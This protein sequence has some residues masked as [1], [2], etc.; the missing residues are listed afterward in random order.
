MDRRTFD[1]SP[2][3]TL[4]FRSVQVGS[5]DRAKFAIC[6]LFAFVARLVLPKHLVDLMVVHWGGFVIDSSVGLLFW[7]DSTRLI[8][9]FFCALFNLMNS[10]MFAIG[11]FPY[12]MLIVLP[13]Y[14][15]PDWPVKVF[16]W[17]GERFSANKISSDLAKKFEISDE[18]RNQEKNTWPEKDEPKV[19][20]R[21]NRL[22]DEA[23]NTN[24]C[25]Q[26]G[27]TDQTDCKLTPRQKIIVILL[28]LFITFQVFLPF[29]HN[30]TKGFNTWTD[31]IYGYSWDMMVHNWRIL[32]KKITIKVNPGEHELYLNTEKWSPNNRWTHHADMAKQFANCIAE[33]L[34]HQYNLSDISIHMDVWISLNGR[35]VQRVFDPRVDLLTVDWSPFRKPSF[36]MPLIDEFTNWRTKLRQIE[37]EMMKRED[38]SSVVFMADFPGN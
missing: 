3:R 35:F 1:A 20:R 22:N 26:N 14:S 23:K 36:V 27:R 29:S 38:N 18:V 16:N 13:I 31:G 12:V 7:F 37:D 11:M 34:R 17:V 8:G 25:E 32:D 10:R 2:I 24:H 5:A 9:Y 4:G 30:I 19:R 21:K 15:S 33:R 28:I 6:V